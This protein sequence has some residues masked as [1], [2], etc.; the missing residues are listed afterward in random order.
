ME[1]RDEGGFEKEEIFLLSQR[2]SGENGQLR[3]GVGMEA[4]W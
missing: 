3:K 4:E 1:G 2:E